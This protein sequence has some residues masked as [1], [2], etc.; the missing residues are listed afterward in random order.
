M[1]KIKVSFVSSRYK[2]E[3]PEWPLCWLA[4]EGQTVLWD[5]G[6]S[7][8]GGGENAIC[9]TSRHSLTSTIV[10]RQCESSTR[11]CHRPG[12][13]CPAIPSQP[14]ALWC[15]SR[16]RSA[17]WCMGT[18]LAAGPWRSGLEGSESDW[19]LLAPC[20][21]MP[22]RKDWGEWLAAFDSGCIWTL[23]CG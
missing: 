23:R 1:C 13:L 11:W 21:S 2:V 4:R 19:E 12:P 17:G 16:G 5:S 9:W 8:A 22:K 7:G 6:F 15:P 20:W 18:P 10:F 14:G 3:C